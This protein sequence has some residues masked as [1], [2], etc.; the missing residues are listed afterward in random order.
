MAVEDVVNQIIT[1]ENA[2]EGAI[3][4]TTGAGCQKSSY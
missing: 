2:L 1:E 3:D 4:L